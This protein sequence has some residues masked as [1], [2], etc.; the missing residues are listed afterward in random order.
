MDCHYII[1]TSIVD[2]WPSGSTA[3][4]KEEKILKA[5]RLIERLTKDYFYPKNF[6]LIMNGNDKNRLY[7]PVRPRILSINQLS[8]D[9]EYILTTDLTGSN[10]E[11]TEFLLDTGWTSTNWTGDFA[12]GWIHTTG[13]TTVLSQSKVAVNATKYKIIY[14]VSGCTAGTFTIA[15]GGQSLESLSASGVWE[16]TTISTD[17]LTITPTLTFN[18]KIVISI[19]DYTIKLHINTTLNA[20]RDSYI[21]IYDYSK[22]E[23]RYWG[24]KILSNTLTDGNGK[25][26]FTLEEVVP[27]RLVSEDT[28]S[29]ITNW[30]YD[31][32]SVFSTL[33]GEIIEPGVLVE[34][35]DL[36]VREKMFTKGENNIKIIGSYGYYNCPQA[37]RDACAILVQYENEPERYETY[38]FQSENLSGAYSYD[39]GIEKMLS[40]IVEVDRLLRNYINKRLVLC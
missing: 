13:H 34:P 27:G 6:I 19:G 32:D 23:D 11:D 7:I 2:N 18:G 8:I 26:V 14:T 31:E 20:F 25:S 37:I 22:T 33:I 9:N 24:C 39:R 4:Q 35:I 28:V 36:Y 16:P 12:T 30:R 15:F 17:N 29:I 5:E 1:D 3:N 10:K 21:S 38:N 40:G